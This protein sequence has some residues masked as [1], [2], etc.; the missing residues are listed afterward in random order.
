MHPRLKTPHKQTPPTFKC[1]L[2]PHPGASQPDAPSQMHLQQRSKRFDP[3]SPTPGSTYTHTHMYTHSTKN[4]AVMPHIHHHQPKSISSLSALNPVPA[5]RHRK[6]IGAGQ[7]Q[8]QDRHV[9]PGALGARIHLLDA[10]HLCMVFSC[11][12]V[13]RYGGEGELVGSWAR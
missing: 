3:P 11:L 1:G 12:V 6:E 13:V 2:S 8:V 10:V 5:L 4:T 7:D 9:R